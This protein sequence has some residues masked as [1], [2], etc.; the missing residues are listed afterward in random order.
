MTTRNKSNIARSN[1]AKGRAFQQKV[2][3]LIL[4]HFTQLEPDDIRSNPMGAPGEDLLLSPTARKL[5]HGVQI[6]CK[7]SKSISAMRWVEQAASHGKHM[8]LVVFQEDG[9]GKEAQAIIPFS[10]LLHLLTGGLNHEV[11]N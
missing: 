4:A 6:E 2:R 5:L 10:Y 3:D 8:P 1:K 7:K 11:N 9:I